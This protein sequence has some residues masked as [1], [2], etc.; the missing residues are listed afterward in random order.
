V[1]W[2][3]LGGDD[4]IDISLCYLVVVATMG[5]DGSSWPQMPDMAAAHTFYMK[6]E[7]T[8]RNTSI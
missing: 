3:S 2:P 1:I 5:S 6:S 4:L 7:I 8:G